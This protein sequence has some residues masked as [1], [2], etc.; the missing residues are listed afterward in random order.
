MS[1]KTQPLDTL[2]VR[3]DS[4]SFFPL[5]PGR[6]RKFTKAVMNG[7]SEIPVKI[8]IIIYTVR[9]LYLGRCFSL[10]CVL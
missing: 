9:V 5:S 3:A 1:Q 8:T 10:V 7:L 6:I 4:Q 2:Y